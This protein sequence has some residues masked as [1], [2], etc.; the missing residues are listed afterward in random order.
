MRVPTE[1][2]AAAFGG[3]SE[4]AA[5]FQA[6]NE[7]ADTAIALG[8]KHAA[9]ANQVFLTD[10]DTKLADLQS[11]VQLNAQT[12][13]GKDALAAR[14]Q[15]GND[16]ASGVQDILK[17]AQPN[18]VV[19]RAAQATASARG[20]ALNS[21]VSEHAHAELVNYEN[22]QT[23]AGLKASQNLAALNANNPAAVT[24]ELDQQK[25]LSEQWAKRQ[26]IPTDPKDPKSVPFREFLTGQHSNTYRAV[27]DQSIANGNFPLASHYFDVAKKTGSLTEQ[28]L[29]YVDNKMKTAQVDADAFA[30]FKKM[31]G[32]GYKLS[33]GAPNL[34]KIQAEISQLPGRTDAQKDEILARVDRLAGVDAR[35]NSEMEAAQDR[36]FMDQ[37]YQ[38]RKN[39][40]PLQ[41][42]LNT[43]PQYSKDL[44][45]QQA[46]TRAIMEV[47]GPATQ[48]DPAVYAAFKAQSESGVLDKDALY[49]AFSQDGKLSLADFNRLNGGRVAGQTGTLTPEDRFNNEALLKAVKSKYSN[50]SDQADF[51]HYLDNAQETQNMSSGDKLKFAME[52]MG[53]KTQ[54]NPYSGM[55]KNWQE[56]LKKIQVNSAHLGQVTQ[57]VGP[58]VVS[59]IQRG[60]MAVGGPGTKPRPEN[61]IDFMD[62]FGGSATFKP[63]TENYNAVQAL[64]KNGYTVNAVNLRAYLKKYPATPTGESTGTSG[65]F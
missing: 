22:E 8:E 34:G 3:G 26:G 30:M 24:R 5:A 49:K 59:A 14:A 61:V 42:V 6:G 38:S 32:P 37:L 53:I 58:D 52:K 40:V 7:L 20:M 4:V 13:R 21:A 64:M 41:Q 36:N 50:V 2:P 23:T 11:K 29:Q 43:V 55:D 48:S 54:N 63:G 31:Q 1:A 56:D 39:G 17:T 33:T 19:F 45:D 28:D 10:I 27:I 46:K 62:T 9:Q 65:S 47:Y 35:K 16:W 25:T 12:L 18:Q 51:I 44:V 15:A 57:E 60:A